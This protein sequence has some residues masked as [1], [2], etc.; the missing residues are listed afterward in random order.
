MPRPLGA[1]CVYNR[2][3]I[4]GKAVSAIRIPLSLRGFG[5]GIFAKDKVASH[6]PIG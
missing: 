3:V 6:P 4:I 1:M 5:R 2:A